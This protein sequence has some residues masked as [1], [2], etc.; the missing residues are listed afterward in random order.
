MSKIHSIPIRILSIITLAAFCFALRYDIPG[1]S[2]AATAATKPLPAFES[3]GRSRAAFI[4]TQA[5]PAYALRSEAVTEAPQTA[6]ALGNALGGKVQAVARPSSDSRILAAIERLKAKTPP[7]AITQETIAEEA[8]VKV[9]TVT[10][11][12][13]ANKQVAAAIEAAIPTTDSRILAAIERLKAKTPPVVITHETI[14][15]EADVNVMTVTNRKQANKQVAAA[16]EAAY[17]LESDVSILAAIERLKAKTPPVAITRE[18]I[19]EEADVNV[20]TVTRRKQANKQVAAA[21]EAAKVFSR[22]RITAA[23]QAPLATGHAS[24]SLPSLR[25]GLRWTAQAAGVLV[26]VVIDADSDSNNRLVRKIKENRQFYDVLSADN[27]DNAQILMADYHLPQNAE[28][29]FVKIQKSGNS[30]TL[31]VEGFDPKIID[32]SEDINSAI[33]DYLQDV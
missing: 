14:A 11:R 28:V 22:T 6:Q 32:L 33:R 16:I 3:V 8:D 27:G 26:A 19:A 10:R 2:F 5:G 18:T 7:V 31:S 1:M 23:G 25:S 12:K 13:Q 24:G 4:A 15:E 20:M 21:I 9:I 17:F 30:L 29:K